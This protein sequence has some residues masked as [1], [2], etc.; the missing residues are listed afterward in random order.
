MS[1]SAV[2]KGCWEDVSV[3]ELRVGNKK[4][5]VWMNG[6]CAFLHPLSLSFSLSLSDWIVV[7]CHVSK[8]FQNIITGQSFN[9]H[10]MFLALLAVVPETTPPA[11]KMLSI[12]Y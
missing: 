11:A 1:V 10:V 5:K 7:H 9:G 4:R 6:E 12:H 3:Y 8:L 2:N